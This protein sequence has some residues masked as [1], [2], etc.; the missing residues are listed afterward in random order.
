M[1]RKA[2]FACVPGTN[3]LITFQ[4]LKSCLCVKTL[5]RI[6]WFLGSW[7]KCHCGIALQRSRHPL[8]RRFESHFVR[9]LS[10]PRPVEQKAT[11]RHEWSGEKVKCIEDRLSPHSC[12]LLQTLCNILHIL[13]CLIG[14]YEVQPPTFS[15]V[16][17]LCCSVLLLSFF[18]FSILPFPLIFPSIFISVSLPLFLAVSV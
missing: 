17:L 7:N 13:L 18:F 5:A 3:V 10:H 1:Q 8:Q 6:R 15:S 9:Q 16:P 2:G 12:C 14:N 11:E 4:L